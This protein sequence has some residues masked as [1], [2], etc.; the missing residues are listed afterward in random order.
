MF[1]DRMIKSAIPERVFSLCLALKGKHFKDEELRELL[2]PSDL[3][4]VTRYYGTV[5]EAARQL[6]LVSIKENEIRLAVDNSVVS[7]YDKFREYI[8]QN[9][10]FI[11]SGLFFRV[12]EEYMKMNDDV[13]KYKGISSNGMVEHMTNMIG[14]SVYEDDMLAWRFWSSFLGLGTLHNMILLPNMYQYLKSMLAVVDLK[15]GEEYTFS[16]FVSL[17]KPY[18]EIGLC[19]IDDSKKLNLGMSNGLRA[20]HDKGIIK[21]SHKLDSGDMWFLYEAE[22]HPIKS[23]VTHVTVRR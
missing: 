6:G 4:G 16:D 1:E 15:K 2:E 10:D 5:K 9:I 22:L 19:D 3:G 12:S 13:F 18:T 11:S 21:L 7:S 8:I 20:L 14:K 23:T 17:I